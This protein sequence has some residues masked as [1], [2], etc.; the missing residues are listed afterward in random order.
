MLNAIKKSLGHS[1]PSSPAADSASLSS[2][3]YSDSDLESNTSSI[4]S[5]ASA[6]TFYSAL[7]HVSETCDAHDSNSLQLI[8]E[9]EAADRKD[10]NIRQIVEDPKMLLRLRQ[11]S[12]SFYR[13][14]N[15]DDSLAVL[16]EFHEAANHFLPAGHKH[17]L[18]ILDYL[19][20]HFIAR[21][22]FKNA[23]THMVECCRQKEIALG[24]TDMSTIK[25]K[26]KLAAVLQLQGNLENCESCLCDCLSAC[27]ESPNPQVRLFVKSSHVP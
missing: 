17:S 25:S 9:Q 16:K 27:L 4:A 12:L 19:A 14:G 26:I 8:S 21:K 24:T 2:A 1:N 3:P 23:E 13:Q 10:T 18:K 20:D 5:S 7:T 22:L 15:L 6:S 11:V